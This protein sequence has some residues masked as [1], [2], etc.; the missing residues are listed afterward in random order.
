M[1]GRAAGNGAD[2]VS[3]AADHQAEIDFLRGQVGTLSQTDIWTAADPP[4]FTGGFGLLLQDL[5]AGDS[6]IN[7]F[8]RLHDAST[9]NQANAK[10]ILTLVQKYKIKVTKP[11]KPSR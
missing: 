11:V 4:K 5:Q 8:S 1:R 7:A 10:A 3:A 9:A 6:L 2:V